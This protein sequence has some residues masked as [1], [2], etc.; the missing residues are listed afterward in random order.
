MFILDSCD[1]IGDGFLNL[2]VGH[3]AAHSLDLWLAGEAR[4]PACTQRRTT[5]VQ[6]LY[7]YMYVVLVQHNTCNT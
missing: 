2:Y 6:L 5:T 7:M 1:F 4:N 3:G